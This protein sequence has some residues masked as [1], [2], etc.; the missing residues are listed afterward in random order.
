MQYAPPSPL[1]ISTSRLLNFFVAER[2]DFLIVGAGFAGTVLAER[3]ATQLGKTCLVIN[4]RNHIGG[5]R[6]RKESQPVR[7][8]KR[9]QMHRKI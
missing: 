1:N 4:R 7:R 9:S 3:V 5:L 8:G 6:S 2:F